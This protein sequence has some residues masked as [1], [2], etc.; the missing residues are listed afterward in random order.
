LFARFGGLGRVAIGAIQPDFGNMSDVEDGM[1]DGDEEISDDDDDDDDDDDNDDDDDDDNEDE[2]ED[3]T[4]ETANE[5]EDEEERPAVLELPGKTGHSGG[6]ATPDTNR[7]MGN[8]SGP[9]SGSGSGSGVTK[10]AGTAASGVASALPSW[11]ANK[12]TRRALPPANTSASS[13]PATNTPANG[14]PLN[15]QFPP[16]TKKLPVNVEVKE[17]QL[18]EDSEKGPIKPITNT[19][20]N[21]QRPALL[22]Q[23]V[24]WTI[25]V[26]L[27]LLFLILGI[28]TA[29][30][31][32]VSA[33]SARVLA[34]EQAIK[35][36]VTSWPIIF[37]AIV[38]QSLKAL[39]TYK[40]ERGVQLFTL[41]QLLGSNSVA[42]A[43]KQPF[44]LRRFDMTAIVLLLLWGLSPLASQAMLRMSEPATGTAQNQTTIYFVDTTVTN[45]SFKPGGASA[46]L[47]NAI[48]S[49]FSAAVLP[50]GKQE[51]VHMDAFRYP[52]IPNLHRLAEFD[53]TTNGTDGKQWYT[54][55]VDEKLADVSTL[56]SSPLGIPYMPLPN[57]NNGTYSFILRSSYWIFDCQDI[58]RG[59]IQNITATTGAN[60]LKSAGGT[61]YMDMSMNKSNADAAPEGRLIFASLISNGVGVDASPNNTFAWTDCWYG[62]V[63]VVSDVFCDDRVNTTDCK[64][65][66]VRWPDANEYPVEQ[67]I[68]QPFHDIFID[69]GTPTPLST[70]NSSLGPPTLIERY[71]YDPKILLHEMAPV[72][73]MKALSDT[74]V[75]NRRI[76]RLFNTFWQAGFDPMYQ[77]GFYPTDEDAKLDFAHGQ[78]HHNVTVQHINATFTD[79]TP[80]YVVYIP[81]LATLIVCSVIL[82]VCGV[83]GAIWE[84]QT[85]G[86]NILGFAN[87]IVRQSK[88]VKLDKGGS[89]LSGAERTR[90]MGNLKVMMQDVKPKAAVGKIA[91]GTMSEESKPLMHKRLYG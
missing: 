14:T 88:H 3:D 29:T 77:S 35:I 12:V 91:L 71:L 58:Q 6:S 57:T 19:P 56:Y 9:G 63:F 32:G 20:R 45:P 78:N 49:V 11:L 4:E 40:V 52:I 15:S 36:A 60:F 72:D 38:A 81:W 24:I 46:P 27:P 25:T 50:R 5:K 21:L 85:I 76:G 55:D 10:A 69:A 62:Q 65:R 41:E 66:R 22:S 37:A 33:S 42:S 17:K 70:R 30:L 90:M 83:T 48:T 28:I 87:S 8:S 67:S 86:P 75:T 84:Y 61:L 79:T 16:A 2:D 7:S 31:N 73:L 26:C 13:R 64:V 43:V 44:F 39:A 54:V 51:P 47:R 80:Q 74:N 59:T 23:V 53:N 89:T 68:V 1:E 18:D 82:L 34:V